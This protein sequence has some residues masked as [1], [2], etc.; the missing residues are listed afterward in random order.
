MDFQLR[1]I[2]HRGEGYDDLV[3]LRQRILRIPFGFPITPEELVDESSQIHL[4]GFEGDRLVACL[5]LRRDGDSM[6]M[7]QVAVDSDVQGAGYG[8]QLVAFSELVAKREGASEMR[9]HARHTAIP[10][11]DRLGYTAEGEMFDE[12]GIPHRI[13]CKRLE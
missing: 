3:E 10:F 8:R 2:V 7:R 1:E 11:Y 13:M 6:R 5:L 12:I 4:A 9:L